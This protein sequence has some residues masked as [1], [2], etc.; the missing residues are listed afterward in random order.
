L[1]EISVMKNE[2]EPKK[3]KRKKKKGNIWYKILKNK[4]IIEI[5]IQGKCK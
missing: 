2:R 1:K 5:V 4:Y 3:E